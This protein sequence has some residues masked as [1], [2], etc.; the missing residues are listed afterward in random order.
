LRG[1]LDVLVLVPLVYRAQWRT[2]FFASPALYVQYAPGRVSAG[3]LLALD[4]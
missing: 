3:G 4:L 1:C 2:G